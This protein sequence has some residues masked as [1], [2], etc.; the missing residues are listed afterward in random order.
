MKKKLAIITTHPIQYNAPLFRIL[1]E[2]N[3]I[4]VKVF[5]TWSQSNEGV[6]DA[7]FNV[8]RK[9]DISLMDGYQYEFVEN[10]AKK[11]DSNRFWGIIN[12]KLRK[13]VKQ[14][15]PDAVIVFRWSV[16]SHL[17]LMQ[18]LSHSI[19]LFFRGDSHLKN[20][21]ADGI[22]KR[23]ITIFFL[24]IIYRKVNVAF[25]VGSYNEE[26]YRAAGLRNEQLI[27]ASHAVDNE[28]FSQPEMENKAIF[29]REKAGIK[30]NDI[31]F[32]YAGKFYKLKK[33]GLLINAFKKNF[34]KKHK[35]LLVGGGE[36]ESNLKELAKNDSRII[37]ENFHNQSDMPWIYRVGDVFV[38]PS[39]S[40]TWGLSVNESM[41]CGRPAIVSDQCGCAPDLIIN[42]KTGYIFR[43][44]DENSLIDCM[45]YFENKSFAKQMGQLAYKHVQNFSLQNLAE[46]IENEM[47]KRN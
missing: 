14:Y 47:Q 46:V 6:F 30:E 5:Y 11:P 36:D 3:I 45:N 42:G 2:R 20:R 35:L 37:F 27:R 22:V 34:N 31:V 39:M 7:K 9:W 13:Q 16:Y 24:K 15:E 25:T 29:F 26:Y 10:I 8:I 21:F 28:R 38:L 23:K 32:L 19:K 1:S 40:E 4:E 18:T 17:L 44:G 43:S 12:P 33:I 41:A